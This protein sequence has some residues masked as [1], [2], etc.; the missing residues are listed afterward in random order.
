MPIKYL[1]IQQFADRVGVT[2]GTI[3]SYNL[4]IPDAY[5]GKTRGWLPETVDEW[6]N[7]RPGRGGTEKGWYL[8]AELRDQ[9]PDQG[10]RGRKAKPKHADTE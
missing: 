3:I 5:I 7:A 6:N 4:P 9:I 10:K 8:P 2:R 1:S